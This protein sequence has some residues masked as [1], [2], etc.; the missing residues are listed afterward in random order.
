MNEN[1]IKQTCKKL[2]ITQKK[3]A[4]EIGVAENTVGTWARGVVEIPASMKKL[5]ELMIIEKK[6]NQVKQ[7]FL[8][9]DSE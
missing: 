2:G 4:E 8:D 7:A 9:S 6:Y 1:I 5:M 3:L